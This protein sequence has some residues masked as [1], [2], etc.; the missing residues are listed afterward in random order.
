EVANSAFTDAVQSDQDNNPATAKI[1]GFG[2]LDFAA[3]G[4]ATCNVNIH[5]N[6]FKDLYMGNFT[7]GNVNLS[8][9]GTSACSFR[10]TGN[11]MDGDALDNGA[12]RIGVNVTA[13]DAGSI[14]AG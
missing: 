1:G 10:F 7:A 11:T 12:G 8:A 4:S 13:G 14:A 2:G 3:D 9:R 6:Q 5:D